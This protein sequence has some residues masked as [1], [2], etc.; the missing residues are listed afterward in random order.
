MHTAPAPARESLGLAELAARAAVVAVAGVGAALADTAPTGHDGAD[1]FWRVLL[2]VVVT[3]AGFSCGPIARIVP[4]V[5]AAAIGASLDA[6]GVAAVACVV[7]VASALLPH[8][9]RWGP[10]SS[11]AVVGAAVPILFRLPDLAPARLTT[12]M[13]VASALVVVVSG[14]R[15]ASRTAR[16]TAAWVGGFGLAVIAAMSLPFLVVG[17]FARGDVNRGAGEA[18]A[19]R[20]RT[21]EGEDEIAAG[22]LERAI[23][24]F[25]QADEELDGWWMGPAQLI[26]VVAQHA[27]AAD[28]GVDSGLRLVRSAQDIL[29]VARPEDLKVADG[30]LDLDLVEDVRTPVGAGADTLASVDRALDALEVDWLLPSIQSDVRKVSSQVRD[31]ERDAAFA[32][33]VLEVL[34][35]L[36]GGDRPKRYFVVFSTPAE[37]RELGGILGN[38]GILT[39]RDG[40]LELE[41]TGRSGDLNGAETADAAVLTDPDSY[42][43]RYRLAD[44]DVYWQ[45]VTSAPDLPTVSRAAA[46]LYQQT[47]GD[48]IDGVLVVDPVALAGLLE[49]TGPVTVP[50]LPEPLDED[51]VVELLLRDQYLD[52]PELGERVDF[53]ADAADATFDRLTQG[54]LPGPAHIADV[55]G[56]VVTSRHLMFWSFD[57]AAQPLLEEVGLAGTL[58]PT[59]DQDV[60]AIAHANLEPNKLDAYLREEIDYDVEVDED[61]GV[62]ETELTVTYTNEVP[63][64]ET[65]PDYVAVN[66]EGRP[67]GTNRLLLSV[68]TPYRSAG[69]EVDGEPVGLERQVELGRNRYLRV[70]EVAPGETVTFS[71]R[72]TGSLQGQPYRLTV[73]RQPLW[74][75]SP[76]A[77][78]VSDGSGKVI[79]KGSKITI[80]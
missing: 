45:N 11:G 68:W 46:D 41:E 48:A 31:A 20:I 2:A 50:G 52:F 1:V 61:T 38:Y 54:E 71:L 19:W 24:A 74:T 62:V 58:P 67:R 57:A 70:I 40:R 5:A 60:L 53:L 34:P 63:A 43:L 69:A 14:W 79:G 9:G 73:V 27:E 49:L 7:L 56:P 59:D 80:Q 33:R 21:S 13:A 3:S 29:D 12:S 22:H 64:P 6:W 77:V 30:A 4:A 39:A 78:E 15:G 18:D 37:A 66:Q 28:T 55:L 23:D 42:P 17:A 76:V 75:S 44:P 8:V 51:G 35:E 26:P 25:Q 36:L 10:L 32:D 72:L 16:R 65:L 47:T